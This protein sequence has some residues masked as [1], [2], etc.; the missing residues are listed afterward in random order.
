MYYSSEVQHP[1]HH[2]LINLRK[3]NSQNK[4]RFEV[5]R[6]PCSRFLHVGKLLRT[7]KGFIIDVT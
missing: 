7:L 6:A 4:L 3:A 1:I 5:F 2:L